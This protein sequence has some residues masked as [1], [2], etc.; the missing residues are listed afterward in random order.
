MERVVFHNPTNGWTVLRLQTEEHAPVSTVVGQLQRLSPGEQVRFSGS[1]K[2]DPKHGRQFAAETCLPLAP[3]TLKG[4]EKFIGSGLIPGVGPVMAERLVK[5]FGMDTLEVVERSAGRLAEVPGIGPKRA[6]AIQKAYLS[7]KS[8]K[9]VMVFLESAGVSPAFAH[10]IYKRYGTDAIRLVSDNP[11]RL[12]NEVTGIG[13]LSADRIASHLGIPKDSSHRAEAGLLFALEE[14]A[15]EGHLFAGQG[16]L[17]P[18]A[19]A[20][21]HIDSV[22]LERAVERLLLMGQ[23][24]REDTGDDAPVYLPRLF[25][26]ESNGAKLLATLL[27]TPAP[28]LPIDPDEAIRM[29]E[30]EDRIE[31]AREQRAAFYALADAKVMVLT[32]GPGTGKTTLLKGLASCLYR[33]G[34]KILL[35]APTGRAA[36]RMAEATGREAMTIHRL[37][38]FTPKSMKFERNHAR[39]LEGDMVIVDEVSMVD[40]ELFTA[41]LDALHPQTRLLLVGDPDQLP[42][43]GPGTVLT[44]L[45]T[46]RGAAGNKLATVRLTEIFRQA[47]SSLIV[48]GAHDILRGRDPQSGER[49]QRPIYFSSSG[50]NP[51]NAWIS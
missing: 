12:A 13:F 47:Q 5:R 29:A 2:I 19:E 24:R 10:R 6:Q 17:I 4:I 20:L 46:L 22:D 35:A 9:D 40:A 41:L 51:R 25:L 15:S 38:E 42:S 31:L 36:R 30:T 44:D 45:L 27:S 50:K 26:A 43:V 33:L 32:G 39:P 18:R 14:F 48:T 37:L 21:L 8:I 23:V 49:A 7:N 28:P 1:W 34:L 11:F 16:K 3:A